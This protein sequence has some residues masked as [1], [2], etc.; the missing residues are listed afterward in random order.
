M[1]ES[2][3][4]RFCSSASSVLSLSYSSS[5][6]EEVV[7]DSDIG[8]QDSV[9]TVTPYQYE[10]EVSTCSSES[11]SDTSEST[12]PESEPS[13]YERLHNRDWLVSV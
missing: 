8:E 5:S 13:N 12:A 10:P 4:S 11:G 3:E 7:I 9:N 1:A 2:E 6:F